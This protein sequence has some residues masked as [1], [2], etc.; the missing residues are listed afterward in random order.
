MFAGVALAAVRWDTLRA[1]RGL[2]PAR[3]AG[4]DLFATAPDGDAEWHEAFARTRAAE[5][6]AYVIVFGGEDRAFVA[7]PDG[8]VIAGTFDGYR[9]AAFTYDRART[10]ATQ[11]APSTDVREGLRTAE[12]I[13]A[14]GARVRV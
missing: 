9:L 5:L 3:L 4:I 2:V 10:A 1:P 7:D 14:D 6:R 12:A 8:A 13:R 11:V